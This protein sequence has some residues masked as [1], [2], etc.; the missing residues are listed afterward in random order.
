MTFEHAHCTITEIPPIQRYPL[1]DNL[2]MILLDD[3]EAQ[4][5]NNYNLQMWAKDRELID[6]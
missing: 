2:S 3:S 1:P 6:A 4:D 5:I